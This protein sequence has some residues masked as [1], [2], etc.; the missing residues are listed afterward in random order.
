MKD[1]VLKIGDFGTAIKKDVF[2]GNTLA[3]TPLYLSPKLRQAFINSTA[4]GS[5]NVS[6]DVY[7]SDV[8][9]L[10]LTFLYMASLLP[11]KDLAI[12]NT[13]EKNIENRLNLLPQQY[14]YLK[15]I[16]RLM[17]KVDENE[18]PDFCRLKE[19]LTEGYVKI[20]LTLDHLRYIQNSRILEIKVIC[21]VCKLENTDENI[22]ILTSGLICKECYRKAGELFYPSTEL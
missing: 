21:E 3:G 8:Y 12:L 15:D 7:K 19:I 18:R 22:F 20:P 5:S 6:H 17:L 10:G 2:S 9:S 13:L 14:Q 4:Q 1:G 16:L 11:V